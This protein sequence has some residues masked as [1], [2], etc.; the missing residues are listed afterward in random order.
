MSKRNKILATSLWGAAVLLMVGI[1]ACLSEIR[2][3]QAKASAVDV[4]IAQENQQQPPMPEFQVAPFSLT[5]QFGQNVTNDIL[6]G[7]VWIAS[8][9]FTRCQQLCP[10]MSAEI[11]TLQHKIKNPSIRILSFSVDP[12]YDTPTVLK[13]YGE[14]Y[15]AD[16]NKW[17]F[18]TGAPTTIGNVASSL[19]L[20]VALGQ[21]PGQLTHSDKL[22]L[23]GPDGKSRGIYT[24]IDD[25][26]VNKL[27]KDAD[28]LA[29]G[30]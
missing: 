22:V 21:N 2:A 15:H 4:E 7:H 17:E 5:N 10:M 8:F 1:V 28:N 29:A 19:K 24:G 9:I 18:L 6:K 30:S 11:E 14:K 12:K 25:N 20:G 26:E 27:A 23:I 16:F 13:A 3:H